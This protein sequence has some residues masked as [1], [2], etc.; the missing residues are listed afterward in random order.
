MKQ[1][2]FRYVAVL[3]LLLVGLLVAAFGPQA[4]LATPVVPAMTLAGVLLFVGGSVEESSLGPVTLSWRQLLGAGYV[5]AA[6]AISSV[7]VGEGLAGSAT[8]RDLF[9]LVVSSLGALTL[10][11]VGVEVA[12]D[13]EHFAVTPTVG[14]E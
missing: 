3:D 13:G 14:T 2:S 8:G 7:Y 6:V 4:V 5:L 12:R 10:V 9:L 1:S 11:V